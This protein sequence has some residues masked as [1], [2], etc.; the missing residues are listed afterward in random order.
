MKE[1]YKPK[2]AVIGLKG[3]PAFG[4][5]AAV[6]ENIIEQL[7]DK[8]DFTVYSISTHTTCKSGDYNNYHQIVFDHKKKSG[9]R[10]L[11]YYLKSVYHVLFHEKYDLIHLHH[12]AA[13]FLIPILRIKYKVVLTTHGL[14]TEEKFNYLKY[15]YK[16]FDWMFLRFSNVITTVS[17]EDFIKVSNLGIRHSVFIPNGIIM[18]NKIYP[19]FEKENNYILFAAGRIYEGKGCHIMLEALIK[20]HYPGRVIIAG[21]L[22][23]KK[24]Y[25]DKVFN[26]AKHLANVRYVGMIKDKEILYSLIQNAK[27]FIYPSQKEAMSMMLLEVSSLRTP[28]ICSNCQGNQDLFSDDE[29]LFVENDNILDWKN[30]IEW[31]LNNLDE[32]KKKSNMAY[33]K[34]LKEHLWKKIAKQYE[35]VFNKLL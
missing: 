26:F 32:M 31:A 3:L 13:S 28:I 24:K 8:Y 27:L 10:T 17:K 9:F 12:N 19:L 16:V 34:L 30:K 35:I 25:K 1:Y 23:Q 14:H 5:A 29:V 18:P 6:G 4:G 2:I 33:N 21:D 20:M 15:V 11:F 7:K 22:D